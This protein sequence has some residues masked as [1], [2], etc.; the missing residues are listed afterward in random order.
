MR[1]FPNACSVAISDVPVIKCKTCGGE[2]IQKSRW[3][4]LVVGFLMVA[5]VAIAFI[6]PYFWVPGLFLL[7]TGGYLIAWATIGKGCWCRTCKRFDIY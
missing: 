2:L 4:L 3:R 7:L 6:V 1:S 5:S